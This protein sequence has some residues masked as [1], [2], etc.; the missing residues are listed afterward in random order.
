MTSK[1]D[2]A[3]LY[4]LHK[5]ER[6]RE[7]PEVAWWECCYMECR[8]EWYP[9]RCGGTRPDNVKWMQHLQ[10]DTTNLSFYCSCSENSDS[11]MT[12]REQQYTVGTR[13]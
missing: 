9:E 4:S 2:D 12:G 13:Y 8:Q 5:Q 3:T 11:T 6:Q 1:E 10:Q 7:R